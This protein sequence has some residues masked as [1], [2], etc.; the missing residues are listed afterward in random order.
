MREGNGGALLGFMFTV[1]GSVNLD[2][3]ASVPRLPAPGETRT[4]T[5]FGRAAGGKGANQAVALARLGGACALIG[6]VGADEA[7]DGLRRVLGEAGVQTEAIRRIEGI[8]TG[9]AL[10]V[11]DEEGRNQI[12]VVEG[13]NAWLTPGDVAVQAALIRASRAVVAQLETPWEATAAA[14]RLARGCG[15]MTVLNA[16]PARD[17]GDDDLGLCDW[18]VVNETEAGF[19][20]RC[21]VSDPV[22]AAGVAREIRARVRRLGVLVTLGAQG[23]WVDSEAGRFHQPAVAVPVVDT[24]GAGD[25]WVG[26]FVAR[27]AEGAGPQEAARFAVAAAALAVT[28]SGALASIPSRQDV[29]RFRQG[30]G[31][32]VSG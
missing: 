28:R 13:A 7:G 15:A 3:V 5:R 1:V 9:T 22:S 12:V 24:V 23:V 18:L 25:T 14:F 27:L 19:L 21:E 32:A 17:L 6:A 10:I 26:A 29:D 30:L 11:V 4:A 31:V 20:G 16:A 8:P 2:W